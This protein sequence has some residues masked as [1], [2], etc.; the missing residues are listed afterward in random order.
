MHREFDPGVVVIL[1][2]DVKNMKDETS[3]LAEEHGLSM[4][5]LLDSDQVAY[6][7]YGITYTPTTV[8]I[9]RHGREIFRHV[10]FSEGNRTMLEK[11]V[12][13]LLERT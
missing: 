13:L 1:V 10:G 7:V 11:E 9:D 6:D 8:I 5:V 4:P 12:R 3:G 2:V